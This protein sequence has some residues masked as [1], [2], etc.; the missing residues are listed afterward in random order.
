MPLQKGAALPDFPEDGLTSAHPPPYP[1]VRV[2][3]H[4]MIAPGPDS[5]TYAFV[6]TNAQQNLFR[7]PLH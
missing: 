5:T 2:I 6:R 1:G 3:D 7:I 4:E